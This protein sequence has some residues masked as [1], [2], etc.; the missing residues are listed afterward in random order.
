[1]GALLLIS[2]EAD[3]ARALRSFPAAL[4]ESPRLQDRLPN[5]RGWYAVQDDDGRW[6]FAPTRWIGYSNMTADRYLTESATA[7][8][9]RKIENRL[10][11]WFTPLTPDTPLHAELHAVLAAF[12]AE[13]GKQPNGAVRISLL[14][15][16]QSTD[17]D[18]D[19]L[20]ELLARV[21]RRLHPT[22]QARL[23]RALKM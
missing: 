11:Q 1:V 23:R 3:A 2:N 5:A 15:T 20:V 19:D 8:D 12:L 13:F 10:V 7:A 17:D 21:N 4:K 14:N 22:Q 18:R 9:G 6:I 16:A